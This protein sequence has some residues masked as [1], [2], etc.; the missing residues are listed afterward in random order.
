LRW[1][2]EA[3]ADEGGRPLADFVRDLLVNFAVQRIERAQQA[4]A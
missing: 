4:G 1:Q 2:L 3:A